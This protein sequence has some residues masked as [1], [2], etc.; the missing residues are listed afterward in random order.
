MMIIKQTTAPTIE[1]V[2]TAE[3]K[4]HLRVDHA[5]DDTY[6]DTTIK[7]AREYL[8]KLCWR[9]LLE[10]T[11][12]LTLP[13]FPSADC[14]TLPK[15]T[16]RSV[17]SVK[18]IDTDGVLQTLATTEYE[19][20]IKSQRGRVVL[21]YQKSWPVTRD[22]WDAVQVVYLV[23]YGTTAA[24]VPAPLRQATLLLVSQ[25]YEQ[26]TPEI[27]GTIVAK[28]GFAVDALAAPYR[29]RRFG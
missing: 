5:L 13:A 22:R 24:T 1:P 18:Y 14:I 26:R 10:Q 23:G 4:A 3:A 21:K 28:I 6:I 27:T 15:G 25:M 9:G 29:L 2:T 17:T 12:E 16:L 20:D 19:L 8:E 7:A 11:W